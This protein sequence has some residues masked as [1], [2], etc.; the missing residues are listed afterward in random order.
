MGG[1]LRAMPQGPEVEAAIR[2]AEDRKAHAIQFAAESEARGRPA[3]LLNKLSATPSRTNS[4]AREP[5]V[6]DFAADAA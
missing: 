3:K 4:R 2:Y 5:Q 1:V 6:G